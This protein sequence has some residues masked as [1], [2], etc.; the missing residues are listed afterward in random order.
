[1]ALGTTVVADASAFNKVRSEFH[2]NLDKLHS[3]AIK[4]ADCR[5]LE[6]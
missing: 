2:S 5:L 1:M 3:V 6:F 4:G